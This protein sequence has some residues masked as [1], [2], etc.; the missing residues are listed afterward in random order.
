MVALGTLFL[1]FFAKATPRQDAETGGMRTDPE[2]APPPCGGTPLVQVR[3]PPQT[4]A[5]G[6]P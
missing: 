6:S 2:S 4:S 3:S 1:Y 5:W